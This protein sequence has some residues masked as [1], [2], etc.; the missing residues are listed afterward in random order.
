[1]T[2]TFDL[3]IVAAFLVMAWAIVGPKSV[4]ACSGTE[5]VWRCP[6]IASACITMAMSTIDCNMAGM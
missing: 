2:S 3:F 5:M 1:M 6:C 4:L